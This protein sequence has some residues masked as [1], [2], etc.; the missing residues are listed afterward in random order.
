ME[1]LPFILESEHFQ[2][3]LDVLHGEGY[4]VIGP[5][6]RGE[7]VVYDEIAAVADLPVGWTDEQSN[8]TYRLKRRSDD[9]YFGYIIGPQSWKKLLHPSTATLWQAARSDHSFTIEPDESD[10]APYAFIGV[11]AC[12]LAAIAIQDKV[13]LGGAFVDPIYKRNREGVFI[14]AVNCTQA[15]GTCFCVSAGTGPRAGA[16][17]DLALTEI[18]DEAQH[19]FVVEVGTERGAAVLDQIPHHEASADEYQHA[20]ELIEDAARHMGRTIDLTE[21]QAR[22]YESYEHP[23]WEEVAERCLM[24]GNCTM[25]CPTCF[26]AT[27][28][29]VIDLAGEHAERRR[30]WDSCFT[31]DFSYIHGGSVRYTPKA[32]YRQWLTHK[33]ATWIDE[34]GMRGCVGCGRCITWCPVGIDITAETRAIQE[35]RIVQKQQEEVS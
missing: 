31:M 14:V 30:L 13:F 6:V 32:R 3:L 8:G 29:D 2:H 20:Q 28:E 33:M 26:C 5:T 34:F 22:L 17:Y 21:T 25:V 12:E 11:R 4:Q 24:C 18:I 7:A 1:G 23:H 9:A 35:S 16:G 19:Y 10:A 27:V 15:G